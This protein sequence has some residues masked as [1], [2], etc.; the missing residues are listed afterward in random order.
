MVVSTSSYRRL[1]CSYRCRY[2]AVCDEGRRNV[3]EWFRLCCTEYGWVCF[4][5][6]RQPANSSRCVI[7]MMLGIVLIRTQPNLLRIIV[8]TT[9]HPHRW[10]L[11]HYLTE[12]NEA[13]STLIKLSS[14]FAIIRFP[15]RL[16]ERKLSLDNDEAFPRSVGGNDLSASHCA[17]VRT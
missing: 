16:F 7:T 17:V 2:D 12:S 1:Y 3:E 13:Q 15:I 14:L 5:L 9:S 8:T 6:A 10:S 11:H 4:L